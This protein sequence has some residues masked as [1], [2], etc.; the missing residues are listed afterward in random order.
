MDWFFH[1]GYVPAADSNRIY[2]QRWGKKIMDIKT[3]KIQ[4]FF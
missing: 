2:Y 4:Y 1:S 3:K